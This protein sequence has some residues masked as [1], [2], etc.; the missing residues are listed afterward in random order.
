MA[1]DAARLE[2]TLA[3]L[4][5]LLE[6]AHRMGLADRDALGWVADPSGYFGGKTGLDYLGDPEKLL[7]VAEQAWGVEW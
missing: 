2:E 1:R 4:R 5:R 6:I 3:T 7:D